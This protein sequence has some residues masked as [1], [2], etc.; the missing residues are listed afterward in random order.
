MA[1]TGLQSLSLCTGC[2]IFKSKFKEKS[3]IAFDGRNASAAVGGKYQYKKP[4]AVETVAEER[5]EAVM[6]QYY[7]DNGV[8]GK[9]TGWYD[10]F[11]DAAVIVEGIH[12][13]WENNSWLT[14]RCVQSGYFSYKV[15]SS[16]TMCRLW[17]LPSLRD[18]AHQR[19][20]MCGCDG[21]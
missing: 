15:S 2:S 5:L 1:D 20:C 4:A 7:V 21:D 10:Y 13:E 18:D 11:A 12:S 8:D 9:A 19:L 17:V 16:R 3:G 6:W 14:V